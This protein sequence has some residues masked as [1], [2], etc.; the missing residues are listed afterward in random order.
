MSTFNQRYDRY[1]AWIDERIPYHGPCGFCGGEDARHR[2]IDAIVGASAAG[3]TIEGLAENY[4]LPE[5]FV[6]RLVEEFATRRVTRSG[7]GRHMAKEG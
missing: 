4:E 5:E 6:R 7:D 3:D 1:P 2:M